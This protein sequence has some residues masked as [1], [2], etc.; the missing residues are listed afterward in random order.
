MKSKIY[1]ATCKNLIAKD[2]KRLHYQLASPVVLDGEE[3]ATLEESD[4]FDLLFADKLL[5]DKNNDLTYFE[6]R[7][8]LCANHKQIGRIILS[9][10]S[11]ASLQMRWAWARPSRQLLWSPT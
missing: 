11:T 4:E 7:C 1:C 9:S 3:Y 2:L 10:G 5:F 8:R 6:L